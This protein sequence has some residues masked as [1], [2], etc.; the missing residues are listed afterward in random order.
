MSTETKGRKCDG[1]RRY[2]TLK[3]ALAAIARLVAQG[4][5]RA[6]LNAYV[7]EFCGGH[8]VGHLGRKT[9]RRKRR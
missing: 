2:D 4:A 8:H 9:G 5:Y 1:K 3:Q 6:R 7:C